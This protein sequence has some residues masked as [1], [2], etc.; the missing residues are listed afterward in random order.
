MEARESAFLPFGSRC[1]LNLKRHLLTA[2][3][4][5]S[6]HG[7]ILPP[8]EKSAVRSSNAAAITE[9]QFPHLLPTPQLTSTNHQPWQVWPQVL[10]PSAWTVGS[11][12]E[13]KHSAERGSTGDSGIFIKI[14]HSWLSEVVTN[15]GRNGRKSR[16]NGEQDS[17]KW[18]GSHHCRAV[19]RPHISYL[20]PTRPYYERTVISTTS[21]I[22]HRQSHVSFATSWPRFCAE[23]NDFNPTGEIT[24]EGQK[25]FSTVWSVTNLQ[26]WVLDVF[27]N[28]LLL[29]LILLIQL[30][31]LI[32]LS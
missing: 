28:V 18:T 5:K 14:I 11:A 25:K 3:P 6:S 1:H 7:W 29:L 30:V 26:Y 23:S 4:Q 16:T 8:S 10:W 20:C 12:A 31:S 22:L 9:R 27:Q 19:M 13:C 15:L 17:S 2:L 32:L 21:G 24:L